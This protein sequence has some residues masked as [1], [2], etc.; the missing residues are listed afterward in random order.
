MDSRMIVGRKCKTKDNYTQFDTWHLVNCQNRILMVVDFLEKSDF[1]ILKFE[2]ENIKISVHID[3]F[4]KYFE[5]YQEKLEKESDKVNIQVGDKIL[6]VNGIFRE[7][8]LE[9]EVI[10]ENDRVVDVKLSDRNVITV[11]K[12]EVVIVSKFKKP[13]VKKRYKKTVFMYGEATV[14]IIGRRTT[15]KLGDGTRGSVYCSEDDNYIEGNGVVL[16]LKKAVSNQLLK[17]IKEGD[18]DL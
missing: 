16:A 17:E 13:V 3:D 11:K 14:D 6:I 5:F 8:K 10:F 2:D 15:V 12:D 1:L 9:G 18:I 4:D 7:S